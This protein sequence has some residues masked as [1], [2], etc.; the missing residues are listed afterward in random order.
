[1]FVKN[2]GTTD[3]SRKST[4]ENS[5]TC[6]DDNVMLSGHIKVNPM[7]NESYVEFNITKPGVLILYLS[8]NGN[9]SRGFILLKKTSAT[10]TEVYESDSTYD[11]KDTPR[12]YIINI[13]EAGVYRLT[14]ASSTI[15]LYGCIIATEK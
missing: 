12:R 2:V 4:V 7:S 14:A 10:E 15:Q 5:K 9:D 3:S 8:P 1:M 11:V 13:Q 6:A